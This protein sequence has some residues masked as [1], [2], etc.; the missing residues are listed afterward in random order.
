VEGS[1][2]SIDCD[3]VML[4]IGQS[5]DLAG[6]G[7]L[8]GLETTDWGTFSVNPLTKE[9]NLPG[10]FAGGDCVTGPDIIVWAMRGGMEAAES[11]DRFCRGE[12]LQK[13]R[14]EEEIYDG[15]VMVEKTINQTKNQV[16]IPHIQLDQRDS[17]TEVVTGYT[18]EQAMEEAYRCMNCVLP[19]SIVKHQEIISSIKESLRE[20]QTTIEEIAEKTGLPKQ[21]TFWHLV[22]MVKYGEAT[23]EKQSYD[24]F[25][26]APKE[27]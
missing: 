25:T 21:D 23:Y 13:D 22:A 12:D 3:E 26:Y 7:N 18:V 15:D 6:L 5:P 27:D 2:F 10:I 1:A 24:C 8:I 19:D 14:D 16:K 20:G 4:A 17:F 11:I 9:T